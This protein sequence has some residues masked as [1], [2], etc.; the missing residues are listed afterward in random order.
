MFMETPVASKKDN[1]EFGKELNNIA[2]TQVDL[3]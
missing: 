1:R 2:I 3:C